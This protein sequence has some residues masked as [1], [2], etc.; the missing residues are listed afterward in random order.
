MRTLGVDDRATEPISNSPQFLVLRTSGT[1]GEPKILRHPIDFH[2]RVVEAGVEALVRSG[3]LEGPHTCVIAISRGRLSG[4]FLFIYEVVRRCRWSVLL[5][6]A[7]DDPDD[8]AALCAAHNVDTVFMAPNTIGAVFSDRMAGRF[9]SVRDLL[10]IGEVPSPTLA[11]R[12]LA[13]FRHVRLRPFI[14]SSNDTGPLGI[15]ARV[16]PTGSTY[17]VPDNVLLEV[18]DDQGAIHL[19]GAGQL[20]V[21]VL[22][23]EDPKLVRWRL[24]DIGVLTTHEGGHQVVEVLGRGEVSTKFH[25]D[26]VGG[27][28]IL[29]QSVVTDFLAACGLPAPLDVILEITHRGARTVLVLHVIQAPMVDVMDLERTLNAQFPVAQLRGRFSAVHTSDE[30]AR[31][32]SP[33][34]RRFF[35]KSY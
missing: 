32:V 13:N 9:D 17:D 25:L 5:L 35:V 4:G 3:M 24:G 26:A 20:L 1:T 11:D 33:G 34:K 8:L 22:G 27:S 7:S 18:E 21:T 28:V 15:P 19:D 2:E 6:G 16:N 30:D 14:Y 31:R 23:L 10:Y 12:L 29:Q